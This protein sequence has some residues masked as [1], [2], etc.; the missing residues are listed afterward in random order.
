M[1]DAVQALHLAEPL[2]TPLQTA[3]AEV[4]DNSVTYDLCCQVQ[5]S[6]LLQ[7]NVSAHTMPDQADLLLP[8]WGFFFIERMAEVMSGGDRTN[9]HVI[10][11]YLYQDSGEPQRK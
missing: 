5:A 6:I 11:L 10:D 8:G 2:L 4:V 7:V 9:Q 1:A 3:L